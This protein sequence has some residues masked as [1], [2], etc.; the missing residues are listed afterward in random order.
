MNLSA[1]H[2]IIAARN[3]FFYGKDSFVSKNLDFRFE[4]HFIGLSK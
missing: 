4:N 3:E 1:S 2:K